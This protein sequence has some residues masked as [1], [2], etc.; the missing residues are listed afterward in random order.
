MNSKQW[1]ARNDV[2]GTAA[3]DVFNWFEINRNANKWK[4]KRRIMA[5]T[6]F[7][8]AHTRNTQNETCKKQQH[9]TQ[10]KGQRNFVIRC[11]FFSIFLFA[12]KTECKLNKWNA[13]AWNPI[14][15][16]VYKGSAL[17]SGPESSEFPL[18]GTDRRS[19]PS[20]MESFLW[21]LLFIL[22]M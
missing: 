13:I 19:L 20:K 22:T 17:N 12:L 3:V 7:G 21:R 1:T 8:C 10:R 18:N 15:L 16:N 2:N 5:T 11:L 9:S 6:F 14:H 4:E